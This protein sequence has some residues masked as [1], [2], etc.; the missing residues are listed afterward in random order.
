MAKS[1]TS[2]MKRQ[3]EL[4]KAQKAAEKRARRQGRV[5]QGF[6]EP[7]PTFSFADL[8]KPAGDEDQTSN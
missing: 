1:H 4:K 7:R 6:E 2:I 5:E 8:E 3:R